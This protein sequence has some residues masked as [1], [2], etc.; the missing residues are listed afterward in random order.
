MGVGTATCRGLCG[1]ALIVA[2]GCSTPSA[3]PPVE[4]SAMSTLDEA[5][6]ADQ[7]DPP[8]V[9]RLDRASEGW[10]RLDVT[11]VVVD[12]GQAAVD[13]SSTLT[14]AWR[15][16]RVDLWFDTPDP[17][18]PHRRVVVHQVERDEAVGQIL[19]SLQGR[20]DA[21]R[22]DGLELDGGGANGGVVYAVTHRHRDTT[23]TERWEIGDGGSPWG[24]SGS[25]SP[26][27]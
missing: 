12:T 16:G 10:L 1:L 26:G 17:D 20:F 9:G 21:S 23:I 8:A 7:R 14:A 22:A 3:G 5:S 19:A 25:F 6:D 4:S 2:A 13:T 18:A 24:S 27:S 11:V 15:S